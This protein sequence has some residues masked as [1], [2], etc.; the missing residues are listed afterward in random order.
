MGTKAARSI[1]ERRLRKESTY[2]ETAEAAG[3]EYLE[4][5]LITAKDGDSVVWASPPETKR[6]AMVHMAFF[7]SAKLKRTRIKKK[8]QWQ[9]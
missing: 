2:R 1:E 3:I 8:F 6:R 9:P 7:I 5:Q 4:M